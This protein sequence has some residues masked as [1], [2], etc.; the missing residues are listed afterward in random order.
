LLTTWGIN[1]IRIEAHVLSLEYLAAGGDSK[2][3]NCGYGH[4]H[5]VNKVVDRVMRVTGV[6]LPVRF[7]DKRPGYPPEL[8]AD[9]SKIRRELHWVP[10]YDD[11]DYIIRTAW[12][13]E[14]KFSIKSQRRP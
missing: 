8:V 5:S 7:V 11:L 10:R 3:Y 14:K 1:L 13:W 6:D 2:V 4:G 9:T 12:E